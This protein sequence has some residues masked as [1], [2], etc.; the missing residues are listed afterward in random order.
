MKTPNDIL[1]FWFSAEAKSHWFQSTDAFDALIRKQ[2][3][4]TAIA[5]AAG[6]AD[7][8]EAADI[9]LAKIIVLDQFSR[10]MYRGTKAAFAW[11]DLALSTAKRM[12]DK[13][14]DVK[15]DQ[16][17]RSFIYMPFMHSET[18]TDQEECVR[19]VDGRLNDNST[20]HH[21]KEHRK[22][23]ARFGRFP[24]RNDI[25]GRASTAE[26]TAFLKGGGYVP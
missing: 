18:L 4:A 6:E 11:D 21:A 14:W 24:H 12:T 17:R 5:L 3:E 16:D 10:N 15:I 8:E 19:L 13:G 2:F 22:V 9:A 20:L 7:W 23:I 26:E 1:E 25:L